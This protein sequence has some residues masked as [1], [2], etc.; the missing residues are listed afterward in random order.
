M[1]VLMDEEVYDE[2]VVAQPGDLRNLRI[3]VSSTLV[4]L[5]DWVTMCIDFLTVF[6][7]DSTVM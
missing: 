1:P 4:D 3:I 7:W 5:W 6:R 2:A